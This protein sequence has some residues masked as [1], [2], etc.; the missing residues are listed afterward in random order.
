MY[1]KE[2][3][4]VMPK[5]Q[6]LLCHIKYNGVI[7]EILQF[8]YGPLQLVVFQCFKVKSQLGGDQ[9]TIKRDKEGFLLAN[10]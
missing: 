4:E 5:V 10:F 7:K 6:I 1:F 3:V 8:D 2:E 9:T